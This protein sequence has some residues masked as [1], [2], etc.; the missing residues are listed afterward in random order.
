M[1]MVTLLHSSQ[2]QA[3]CIFISIF[4]STWHSAV[5]KQ[6][7]AQAGNSQVVGH[8]GKLM[9]ST[10]GIMASLKWSPFCISQKMGPPLQVQLVFHQNLEN[11]LWL[12][13]QHCSAQL[14]HMDMLTCI[15]TTSHQPSNAKVPA[16]SGNAENRCRKIFILA[17]IPDN[18]LWL[19]WCR[20]SERQ[21]VRLGQYRGQT[22]N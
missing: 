14:L 12:I 9:T 3:L 1:G 21:F 13:S 8:C 17:P 16:A 19:M 6:Q 4:H 2:F 11:T 18:I 22:S 15:W 5:R 7:P 20:W 10:K